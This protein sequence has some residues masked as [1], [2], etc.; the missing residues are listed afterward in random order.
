M[1]KL[2]F[3]IIG[4]IPGIIIMFFFL[5][6]KGT[7]CSGYLPNSRVIAEVLSKKFVYDSAFVKSMKSQH[8]DEKFLKDSLITRGEI[9]FSKSE[10]Q[11]VP[12]P[13]YKLFYKG[14][15]RYEVN[16]EKR[17]KDVLFISL[18]NIK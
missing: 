17:E 15:K 5:N 14:K 1:R 4:L 9:D 7:Q 12:F 18:E 6:M 3:Y 16:F 8:I 2:K 10:A 13:R 11:R